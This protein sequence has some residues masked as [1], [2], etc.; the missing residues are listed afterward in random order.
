MSL[1]ALAAYSGL[2]L[3]PL[4]LLILLA[5][6]ALLLALTSSLRYRTSPAS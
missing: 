4:P 2:R 1:R 5:P 6:P 3:P